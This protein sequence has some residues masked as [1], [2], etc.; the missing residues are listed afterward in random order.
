[1]WRAT[2]RWSL[3]LGK[4]VGQ[5][6]AELEHADADNGSA[7]DALIAARSGLQRCAVREQVQQRMHRARAKV[8]RAQE[9]ID[10]LGR[11]LQKGQE[12]FFLP[13]GGMEWTVRMCC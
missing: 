3:R 4:Q 7:V 11:S 5:D 12:D 8:D 10:V 2:D 1:M 9:R 13:S 6:V